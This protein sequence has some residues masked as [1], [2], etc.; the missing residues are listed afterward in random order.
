MLKFISSYQSSP[1]TLEN[2]R[3]RS[4]FS[5]KYFKTQFVREFNVILQQ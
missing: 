4:K 5:R 2:K 1:D 3:H